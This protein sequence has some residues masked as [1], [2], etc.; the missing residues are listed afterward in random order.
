MFL[1]K[2]VKCNRAFNAVRVSVQNME[3][4]K[5][6]NVVSILLQI[7]GFTPCRFIDNMYM[8]FGRC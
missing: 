5:I 2:V 6:L 8:T 3:F 7:A 1:A 4:D